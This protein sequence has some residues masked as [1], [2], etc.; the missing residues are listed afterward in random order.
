MRKIVLILFVFLAF[1]GSY[2][3]SQWVSDS[4]SAESPAAASN[5]PQRMVSMAP[6]ITEVVYALGLEDRLVGV[7]RYCKYPV[8]AQ[9][10]QDI[11]GYIDPN[12]EAIK[13][14]QADLVLL[15]PVHVDSKNRLAEL[16]IPTMEMEHRTAAGILDSIELVGDRCDVKDVSARVRSEIEARMGAVQ[17]K[18]EGRSKPTVL[19]SAA[20]LL[21]T[22]SVDSVYAAGKNQWYDEIISGAGGVNVYDDE[23]VQFPELYKEALYRLDPDVIIEM[24]HDHEGDG[25][26]AEQVIEEWKS[27]DALRAV[28]EGKVF[29]VNGSH[30]QIPGPRFIEVLEDVAKVLHPEVD[31]SSR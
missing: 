3:G 16:N 14:L 23:T 9:N 19:L 31:W 24:T 6:S 29:V 26:S 5:S 10:K 8:E 4:T 2:M 18:V 21:G 27:L 1:A 22:G 7:T 11:G 25:L 13:T 12:Y 30:T 28:K 17:S 20:R 15:L